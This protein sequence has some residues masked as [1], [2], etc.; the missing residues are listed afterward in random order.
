MKRILF[1]V[2]FLPAIARADFLTG[3]MMG[4]LLS[5]DDCHPEEFLAYKLDER[6][7]DSVKQGKCTFDFTARLSGTK[8]TNYA[9]HYSRMGVTLTHTKDDSYTADLSGLIQSCKTK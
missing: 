9:D 4:S 1:M 6:I 3:Y 7:L 2:L 8:W 5:S